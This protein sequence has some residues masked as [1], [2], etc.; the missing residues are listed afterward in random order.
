MTVCSMMIYLSTARVIKLKATIKLV[1][2]V[3]AVANKE[4]LVSESVKPVPSP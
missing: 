3:E 2:G 4:V 1:A